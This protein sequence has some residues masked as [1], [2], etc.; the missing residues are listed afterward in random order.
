MPDLDKVIVP[1]QLRTYFNGEVFGAALEVFAEVSGAAT[2]V[3]GEHLLEGELGVFRAGEFSEVA[4]GDSDDHNN[5]A[6]CC[7]I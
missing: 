2:A 7:I 3:V 6:E 4:D 5:I 1:G